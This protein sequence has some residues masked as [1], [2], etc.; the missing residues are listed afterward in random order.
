ME[1]EVEEQVM[2]SRRITSRTKESKIRDLFRWADWSF[3][4]F[5]LT[6]AFNYA[7]VILAPDM[8]WVPWD[9]LVIRDIQGIHFSSPLAKEDEWIGDIVHFAVSFPAAEGT[10]EAPMRLMIG[11]GD[12]CGEPKRTLT[13]D[14]REIEF[15]EY[16]RP[17]PRLPSA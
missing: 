1:Q 12:Y 15:E 8:N 16:P 6:G 5:T 2:A 3:V 7:E 11:L 9:K 10:G 13:V 4:S 14:C 17:E